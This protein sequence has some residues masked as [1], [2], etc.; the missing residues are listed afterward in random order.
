MM[1]SKYKHLIFYQIYIKSFSDSNGDGIG[2]LQGVLSKIDY[3]KALGINA[4]WLTPFYQTP[5]KDNGYDISDYCSVNADMGTM[6]D[7]ETLIKTFHKN[8]IF[9]VVDLVANHTSTRHVWFEKSRSKKA[10]YRDYYIWRKTPPNDWKSVF[11]GTA[12]QFDEKRGEYYL[13]SFTKEQADVNWDNP[14]VRKEFENIVDFWLKKGADGFRCDVL[15]MISKDF[16]G[17]ENGNGEHLHE[18]IR[19]LFDRKGARCFTVGECWSADIGSAKLL[20]HPSR[21]ELT[22]LFSFWHLCLEKGRFARQKPTLYEMCTRLSAWQTEAYKAGITPTVFFENHDLP[23]S[24]SRFANDKKYRYESATLLGAMLLTHYGIPFIFQG[25]EI[26]LTNSVH[27]TI[28]E[29][30]DVESQNFYFAKGEKI[31]KEERL[32]RINAGGRDNGRRMMPWTEKQEKGWLPSYERQAEINVFKDV[33]QEESVF[34]FYQK[35][36]AL[37]KTERCLTEGGYECL[38]LTKEKYVFSRAT[39]KEKIVVACAFGKATDLPEIQGKILLSNYREPDNR[40]KPYQVVLY[41]QR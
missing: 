39:E 19:E 24:V 40:L 17:G 35:L 25:E 16:E 7:I 14:K 41:K 38:L 6:N 12:W 4:V 13:C 22:T 1:N 21:E 34:R 28:A 33:C 32:R 36:I 29:H 15:D 30:P 3:L 9:V 11:G 2:D 20:T 5:N 31:A 18:Y 37:R 27:K 10:N 26:G 8:G 23:R